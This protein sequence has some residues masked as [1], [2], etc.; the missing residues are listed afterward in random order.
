MSLLTST[1]SHCFLGIEALSIAATDAC[2]Y[3]RFSESTTLTASSVSLGFKWISSLVSTTVC[4]AQ[5]NTCLSRSLS[6]TQTPS[7]VA[8]GLCFDS[9]FK[10]HFLIS[11]GL[12][13]WEA[14][15]GV[16]RDEAFAGTGRLP[17]RDVCL[18]GVFA[19]IL[20]CM[21][22]YLRASACL[23]GGELPGWPSNSAKAKS[24][25]LS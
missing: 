5:R 4:C 23:Y 14:G 7:V 25:L 9:F 19:G 17:G 24:R 20:P 2:N 22:I 12:F 16:C 3:Y 1:W 15:R 10:E 13:I 11:Q 21:Y 18:D 8:S 6:T